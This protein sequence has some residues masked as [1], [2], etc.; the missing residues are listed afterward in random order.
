MSDIFPFLLAAVED[1]NIDMAI[2][3]VTASVTKS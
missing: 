1:L 3:D 2:Y